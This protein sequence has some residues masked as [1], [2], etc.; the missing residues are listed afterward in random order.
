MLEDIEKRQRER[1]GKERK[2]KG[3]KEGRGKLRNPHT[4]AL[5]MEVSEVVKQD[6]K[7][8]RWRKTEREAREA[9]QRQDVC[10]PSR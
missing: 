5:K 4:S 1:K 7:Q 2:R 10:I 9:K 8:C 6:T 3:K